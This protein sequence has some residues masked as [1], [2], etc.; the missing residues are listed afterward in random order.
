M[1]TSKV[2][3]DFAIRRV[4]V[5]FAAVV[6]PHASPIGFAQTI[7]PD[8]NLDEVATQIAMLRP[9]PGNDMRPLTVNA[10]AEQA[11]ANN[12]IV[13]RT[14]QGAA[15][16]TEGIPVGF[17]LIDGDI[18]VRVSDDGGVAANHD[19]DR[20]LGGV[21]PYEFD[22]NV[23]QDNAD[24]I[25]MAMQWWESVASVDF[26]PY[27]GELYFIH[28]QSSNNNNS[29]VGP[30][31]FGQV[32]NIVSWNNT[33]IMAHEL[34]H[35]LGFWHEQSRADR[36]NYVTINLANVCQNC[37]DNDPCDHN[38]DIE[39]SSLAYGPYDFDSVMH[40]GRCDFST[41]AM[42][43]QATCPGTIGETVTVKP[44]FAQWQC[45]NPLTD[46]RNAVCTAAGAP[47]ACCTGAGTGTCGNADS[48]F[49]GQR[50][51]LSYWDSLV[52]S[53][54]YR[55]PNWRFQAAGGDDGG[56]GDFIEPYA[57][58][59]EGWEDTPPGGTLW[60]LYPSAHGVDYVLD[61]PMTIAAPLGGVVLAR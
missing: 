22:D 31:L 61:K 37:C 38:F 29:A 21:I 44:Q 60:V 13:Y 10:N 23:S 7:K 14:W 30:K 18:Q 3:F 42:A 1:S 52:M 24:A 28:I 49:I 43:C 11:H 12:R 54:M 36:N 48:T 5:V 32:V 34:G 8:G 39:G 50:T 51:H 35:A 41:N 58:L 47:F 2:H 27:D 55:R 17:K 16:T 26:R 20:W 19:S 4:A 15:L 33:A 40:Y 25:G 59:R 46:P 56:P 57:T 6:I 53:F 45:G 9:E